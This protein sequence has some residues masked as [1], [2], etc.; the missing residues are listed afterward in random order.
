MM[1]PRG[2]MR[3]EGA[4]NSL[5]VMGRA[6]SRPAYLRKMAWLMPRVARAVP[7]LGFI[8]VSG[9]KPVVSEAA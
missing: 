7:Y 5:R 3:D 6:L 1:T 2:F 8:L 4:V 9:V